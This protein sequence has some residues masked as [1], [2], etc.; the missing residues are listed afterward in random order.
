[1]LN[2]IRD[3]VSDLAKSDHQQDG[4]DEENEEDT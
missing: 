1:M 4:E 2:A 3:S